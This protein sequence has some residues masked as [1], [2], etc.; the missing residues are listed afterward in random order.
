MRFVKRCK[1]TLQLFIREFDIREYF[2][3]TMKNI[4]AYQ[5]GKVN[6]PTWVSFDTTYPELLFEFDISDKFHVIDDFRFLIFRYVLRNIFVRYLSIV[7]T[8][9]NEK[10]AIDGIT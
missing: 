4:T 7:H 1:S 8:S 10:S 6:L 2:T 9:N 5:P 3:R